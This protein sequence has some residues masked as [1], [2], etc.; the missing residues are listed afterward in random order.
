MKNMSR[1]ARKKSGVMR[2]AERAAAWEL[3][4]EVEKDRLF[5]PFKIY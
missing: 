3:L 5:L 2:L 4:T 1:K